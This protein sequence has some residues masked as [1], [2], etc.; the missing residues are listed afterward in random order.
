MVAR[1]FAYLALIC[2]FAGTPQPLIAQEQITVFAAASL[3]NALDDANAAFTT[4]TGVKVVTSYEA[5]S[6][7]AKQIEQGAP[8]DVFISADLR[9]ME[10][11]ALQVL[12]VPDWLDRVRKRPSA[13][14]EGK[15]REDFIVTIDRSDESTAFI[16][17]RCQLPPR[18][19]TDYLVA[20]KLNDGWQIVS[21][22]Y[23]YDLKE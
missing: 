18:Y 9:W 8:A 10:K 2:A 13:K 22:S 7:L 17:V 11:G 20:M 15:P 16:K 6:A 23:R 5:S 21:K 19:F 14:A 4:A 12:T 3:T 1:V